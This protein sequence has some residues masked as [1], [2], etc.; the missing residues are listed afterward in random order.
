MRRWVANRGERPREVK[1]CIELRRGA[2]DGTVEAAISS[3]EFCFFF[4]AGSEVGLEENSDET[5]SR[6]R[7]SVFNFC[8]FRGL[9]LLGTEL[10][11]VAAMASAVL[12]TALLPVVE[13]GSIRGFFRRCSAIF[14][15]VNLSFQRPPRKIACDSNIPA[16]PIEKFTKSPSSAMLVNYLRC[17]YNRYVTF[18]K[19]I[20][21]PRCVGYVKQSA[22]QR[23]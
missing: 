18:C 6:G 8:L 1:V 22:E 13:E 9:E 3:K 17:M 7:V 20:G 23:I 5:I 4:C 12:R 19:I 15:A 2:L 10:S 21:G 14:F 16:F 11:F